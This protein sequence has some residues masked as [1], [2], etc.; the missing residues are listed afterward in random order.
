MNRQLPIGTNFTLPLFK[1]NDSCGRT[2][3]EAPPSQLEPFTELDIQFPPIEMVGE[4][5]LMT[6]LCG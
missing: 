2:F 4:I 3:M 5:A 1:D 6:S